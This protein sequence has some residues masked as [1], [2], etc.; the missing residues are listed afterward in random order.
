MQQPGDGYAD[1]RGHE[2][3]DPQHLLRRLHQGQ[4]TAAHGFGRQR[5]SDTL[6]GEHDGHALEETGKGHCGVAGA[7]PEELAGAGDGVGSGDVAS[8]CSR[9]PLS[10]KNRKNSDSGVMTMRVL[11]SAKASR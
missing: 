11:P 6:Q 2:P 3:P 7:E 9:P 4:Q 8:G 1:H 5:I 10:R